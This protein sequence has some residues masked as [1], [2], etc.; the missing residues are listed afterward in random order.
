VHW[1]WEDENFGEK[2]TEL[3]ETKTTTLQQFTMHFSERFK[4]YFYNTSW[5]LFERVFIQAITIIV[6]II[7]TRYQGPMRFGLLSYAS[8]YIGLFGAIASLGLDSIVVQMLVR[9]PEDRETILGTS[10][11][12]K[13]LGSIV[14]VL[15]IG[16]V[17]YY[18]DEDV[19]SKLLISIV[20]TS[21][22]FQSLT[23]VEFHFTAVVASKYYVYARTAQTIV[24]SIIRI[25]FVLLR[26]SLV[27]FAWLL[28]FDACFLGITGLLMYRQ[29]G[30]SLRHWNFK[31]A[32]ATNL[33]RQSWPLMLST[34]AVGIYMKIDQVMVK[35]MLD[36]SAVGYYAAAVRLSEGWYFIPAI[37][38]SSLFPAIIKAKSLGAEYYRSSMLSLYNVITWLFLL[39]SIPIAIFSN[40]I[41][42][43]LLGTSFAAAGP[44][45]Q[46]HIWSAYFVFIG[47]A[48]SRW[49]LVEN[50]QIIDLLQTI[51]GA[52]VNVGLNIW[53]I[54]WFGIK[55]AAV[56][57]LIAYFFGSQFLLFFF[58]KGRGNLLLIVKAL[59][60]R[61][62][63][64]RKLIEQK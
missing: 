9:K 35:K 62:Q 43:L 61:P 10:F 28:V 53:F 16:T 26:A 64:I 1:S 38:T 36:A 30:N 29:K 57:T 6:G 41:V 8:S 45:L 11:L 12:L 60:P 5:L 48:S 51:V 24:S 44:V 59:R 31:T 54:P 25:M 7:V 42:V 47:V 52:I 14:A 63:M 3:V 46:I 58:K 23:V 19:E 49:L 56:S 21:Y 18:S 17:L 27:W 13:L 39:L 20:S 2:K 40:Q 22:I 55:G 32:T 37:I 33:L 50:L 15:V 34:I 4:L